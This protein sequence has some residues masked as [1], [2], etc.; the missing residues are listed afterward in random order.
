[1]AATGASTISL[2]GLARRLVAEELISGADAA[3]AQEKSTQQKLPLVTYLVENGIVDSGDIGRLASEEFGIPLFDVLSLDLSQAPV[4]LVSE[5]LINRHRALPL[6]KRGNR[7]YVG[8]SDPTNLRALDEIKFHANLAVEAILVRDDELGVAI[9]NALTAADEIMEDLGDEEGLDDVDF[10][11]TDDLQHEDSGGVEAGGTDDTPVVRFVNKVLLD[12]IKR[13]ASD[14]HFEPYEKKYRVRFRMDGVLKQMAS[15]PVKM[16]PRLAA[17]LKVMSS[18]DIA[19]KRI[20]QDGRI[21]LN[22]SKTRAIDFR[23]STC[24]TLFG[25][26]IVLRIL[27]A[28][29]AKMGIDKLGYEEEQK[30]LFLDA[31]HK[32]Y[33]MVL[34]TGPTGSGKTVSL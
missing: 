31:I 6:Y 14:I 11:D 10:T 12:A 23:V 16:T 26:K 1:M 20:P 28:S 32:P 24:P 33:G 25:E 34:V 19:E 5:N 29:A 30:S 15:P 7:M 18:L 27:D 3:S 2:S 4:K 21:K 9:D 13:G 8:V 17:R 22:I